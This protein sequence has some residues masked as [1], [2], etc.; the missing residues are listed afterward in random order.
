MS[1]WCDFEPLGPRLP[2]GL[3]S[4]SLE[5]CVEY[6]KNEKQDFQKNIKNKF[7]NLE[8]SVSRF[9]KFDKRFRNFDNTNKIFETLAPMSILREW[10]SGPK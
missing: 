4:G 3:A 10:P 7:E 5:F 9:S 6:I 1:P 8:N 2:S